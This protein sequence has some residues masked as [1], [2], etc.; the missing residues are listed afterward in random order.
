MTSRT[1]HQPSI[2]GSAQ[3]AD[4]ATLAEGG[5]TAVAGGAPGF[6]LPAP[7]GDM[8]PDQ[9]SPVPVW[10]TAAR[11]AEINELNRTALAKFSAQDYG[12]AIDLLSQVVNR[13][14]DAFAAHG[15][16]AIALRAAKRAAEAE[17]HAR[18]AVALHPDYAPGYKMLAE[19]LTERRDIHGALAAYERLVEREPANIAAH[20]NASLLLRKLGKLDEAQAAIARASALD[21]HNSLIRFNMLMI[22]RDDTVLSEATALCRQSLERQPTSPEI[23]TNLA[24]C[25][26]FTG[27]YDEAVETLERVVALDPGHREAGFNLALL[28][29]L[30]GDFAQGWDKYEQRRRLLEVT[31]PNLAQPEW[32]GDD[33]GGRT[34]LLFAEQGFGDTIQCLR[35]VPSVAARAGRVILYVERPLVR[36]AASLAGNVVILPKGARLPPFDVWCPML[37]LPRLC[38]TGAETIPP[39]PYLQPRPAV[40]ERWRRRL[41][42]LHGMKIGLAWG[43][44]PHHV[45]DYRRSIDLERLKPL[46]NVPGAS[47]VS[48]QVGPRAGEL[49]ALPAGGIVDLSPELHDF[50]ETAGAIANLDL[51]IGVD[52]A[53]V[54]VA[55][56][57][58]KPVWVMLPFS[59]DW[60]WMLERNDSPWY[61]SL[62][63]YRQ[64][65]PGDWG[66]VIEHVA[67]DLARL[68]AKHAAAAQTTTA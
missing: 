13:C 45:N 1:D 63:L 59:P 57:V 17:A 20:N 26:Q 58:A 61:P 62:R 3:D 50:A 55:G 24:V 52:T 47:F 34:I 48:L 43:G 66:S 39:A 40:A 6:T 5:P 16:Y 54:H 29:L 14:P 67:A 2:A 21:P 68:V 36:L 60:R 46:L 41:D 30:R 18:R 38:Q 12:A 53:V 33:L 25:L 7:A 65:A 64:P 35:Y 15:N 10:S 8:V 9:F 31:K 49:V 19:L 44:S 42:G 23:L 32:D 22:K 4:A 11:Q 56:A 28:L 37:S 27:H 51:V